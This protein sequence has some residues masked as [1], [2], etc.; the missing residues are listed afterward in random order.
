M[1]CLITG[2]TGSIGSEI[3]RQLHDK[4]H[5]VVIYSRQEF[6]QYELE[7]T[8]NGDR[9]RYFIGDVRDKDRLIK[10]MR[11]CDEVYHAAGMK[12]VASCENNPFEAVQTNV[13][14]SQNIID[15]AID[16]QVSRCVGISTDKAANPTNV[17]G[18]TK[19]LME[20]LFSASQF[21][22]GSSGPSFA[23]VRFGNVLGSRGSVVPHW[24]EQIRRGRAIE[25]RDPEMTRYMMT[26]PDAV[27]LVIEAP[28][29]DGTVTVL[30]M[31]AA[32]VGDLA[33]AVN[34][35]CGGM[36]G[37]IITEPML[38]EKQHE[39]LITDAEF[40]S[41]SFR[42]AQR[43]GYTRAPSGPM[44]SNNARRFS[45]DELHKMIEGLLDDNL[46]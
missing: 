2:G 43:P 38:G 40:C 18:T 17:M 44:E 16:C 5:T 10:A 20:R 14:G 1:R 26:I 19:K 4:G 8:L 23:C 25:V 27:E 7:K 29:T 9:V 22:K 28:H 39:S 34:H 24:I 12:H 36:L 32:R 46:S 31:S 33:D 42:V 11:G 37:T 41:W 21:H 13:I 3:A 35:V 6:G 45:M 30:D 15:A